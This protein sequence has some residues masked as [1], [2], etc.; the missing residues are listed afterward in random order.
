MK[1]RNPAKLERQLLEA[2]S[3]FRSQLLEV[4]PRVASSGEHL[5]YHPGNTPSYWRLHWLS[6]ESGPLYALAVRCV[7]LRKLLVI[8]TED[9]LATAFLVACD[10][11]VDT[12]NPHRLGARRRAELLLAQV[13][14]TPS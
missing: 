8:S 10:E 6:P 3:E 14:A 7:E 9:C 1:T 11:A 4:L 13:T 2:E 5:F 12:G